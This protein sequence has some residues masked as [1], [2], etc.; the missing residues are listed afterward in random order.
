MIKRFEVT[1]YRGFKDT[2]VFDLSRKRDYENNTDMIRN[3]IINKG[4][5]FGANGSGKTN[6]GYALFDITLH[7]TDTFKDPKLLNPVGYRNLDNDQVS[8]TFKYVFEFDKDEIVYEYVKDSPLNLESER[9]TVNGKKVIDIDYNQLDEKYIE[10]SGVKGLDFSKIQDNHISIIK[11][12]YAN[13]LQG[14]NIYIQKIMDFV[15]GMLWFRSLGQG[16]QFTGVNNSN[17]NIDQ[18]IIDKGKVKDLEKFLNS[19]G[20]LAKIKEEIDITGKKFL[21]VC[22]KHGSLP[23]YAVASSGTLSLLLSFYWSMN[24][25]SVTFMFVDEFDA[26]L[27]YESSETLFKFFCSAFDIQTFV[28]THNTGLMNNDCS[29]PDCCFLLSNNKIR[30]ICDCTDKE[31]RMGHNLEKMYKNGAFTE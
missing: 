18:K 31:L 19:N 27:H 3:G 6:L 1:N 14:S 28:T 16:N 9:L 29:R 15:S 11:F 12:I 2:L 10:L 26:Y 13:T 4:I 5:I 17:D 25:S 21:A 7:L 22:Y 8:V 23:L 30:G 20:I 24:F